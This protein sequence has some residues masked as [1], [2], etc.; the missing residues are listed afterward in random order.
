L[1]RQQN[2]TYC[3]CH[4]QGRKEGR[5]EL[6]TEFCFNTSALTKTITPEFEPQQTQD[7]GLLSLS[8]PSTEK[9][10]KDPDTKMPLVLDSQKL[11]K[12]KLEEENR[13]K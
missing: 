1:Q 12:A 3:A 8:I 13:A 6:R 5:K 2:T 10:Q 11:N 9:P 7:S 4:G